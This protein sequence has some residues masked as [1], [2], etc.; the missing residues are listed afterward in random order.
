[1]RRRASIPC[2]ATLAVLSALLALSAILALSAA[3]AA[4]G[5]GPPAVTESEAVPARVFGGPTA[6]PSGF[7]EKPADYAIS[8]QQALRVADQDPKILARKAE[9]TSSDRLTASLSAEAVDV[10]E[11]GYYLNDTKVN[12]VIVDGETGVATESWTGSAVDW[13]MARGKSGQFGHVL[14]AP[15]VWIPLALIFLLGLWDFRRWRKWVHLDLLVLLSFGISQAFFN[16]AEIG[17]SVPLYYPPLIYLLIRMLSIGFRGHGRDGGAGEGLRPSMPVWLMTVA[18]I[19][20]IALRLAGNLA[21]SGVIDVGYAGV[22]GADKITHAEP[23]YDDSFPDD[24]PTG[25]TYGPANYFA[26]VPFEQIFPWG[27][28]WDDLP[29]A[30]AA[31]VFFDFATIAGLFALGL[32]LVRR[33]RGAG[34]DDADDEDDDAALPRGGWI[35]RRLAAWF[36]DRDG[37]VVGLILVFAWV[38]Y[39]YTAF[40]MQGNSNDELISALLVWSLAAFASPFARG[41]LLATASLAKFVPLPLFPLYAAGERGFRFGG[42][43]A[44]REQRRSLLRSPLVL[45]LAGFV[46]FAGLFLAYPAVDP[47]LSE[48][49]DR[50]VKSQLDRESPFSIW[51]QADLDWLHTIV[52]V[53]VVALGIGVAFLPRRRTLVQI[54]ALSAAVIIAVE[55]TL[56]HWFYLYLPWFL[57]AMLLAIVARD[58]DRDAAHAT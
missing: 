25:D 12:L 36:P 27:G 56:E 48:F 35:R 34:A 47:G 38:A 40:A 51:G 2:A 37:N 49:Y 33:R 20:L 21:D 39:P 15:Y 6:V 3:P 4:A 9:L 57:G 18:V 16:A 28:S 7:P 50:T 17:V 8:P 26:Y 55:I 43:A 54:A 5:A 29:A 53:A 41:A 31:A 22:I 42:R 52:K 14:N 1:V 24:N 45:F 32:A 11:V 10:W 13:P 30:H 58:A 44:R 19:G 46:L 23:I